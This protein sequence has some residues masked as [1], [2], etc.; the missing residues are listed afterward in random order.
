MHSTRI[1]DINSSHGRQRQTLR[2]EMKKIRRA[3]ILVGLSHA[4][5]YTIHSYCLSLFSL[6][7]TTPQHTQQRSSHPP[8]LWPL[9]AFRIAAHHFTLTLSLLH[10]FFLHHPLSSPPFRPSPTAAARMS[11]S[12]SELEALGVPANKAKNAAESK[13]VAPPLRWLLDTVSSL[14]LL[15]LS[16]SLS[17]F[18]LRRT[19]AVTRA[20]RPSPPP[21]FP[22]IT[23]TAPRQRRCMARLR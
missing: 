22:T 8:S 14:F 21:P 23:T 19:A 18:S 12:Q 9:L 1:R 11:V 4:H 20:H 15:S 10:S 17:L 6:G 5:T 2:G 16:L 3:F 13:Q 7:D